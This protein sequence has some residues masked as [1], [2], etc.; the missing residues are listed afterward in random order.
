MARPVCVMKSGQ[1]VCP[2]AIEMTGP[3]ISSAPALVQTKEAGMYTVDVTL[4]ENDVKRL[5][6]TEGNV[7]SSRHRPYYITVT[8]TS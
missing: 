7:G 6:V 1:E 5:S 8:S 2:I 4:M 3:P